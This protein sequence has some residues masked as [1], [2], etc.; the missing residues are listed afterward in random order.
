M[1]TLG[2]REPALLDNARDLKP[3]MFSSPLL[4]KVFSQ[5]CDR[6]LLGQSVSLSG[7]VGFEPEEMSHLA[8]LLRQQEGPV[9]E[10]A[11]VDCVQTIRR[12]YQSSRV[13]TPEDLLALRNKMKERKGIR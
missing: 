3:E 8:L 1:I 10:Q 6:H 5:M 4:G 11:F 12:E 9:N 13:Q 7:M 2:F